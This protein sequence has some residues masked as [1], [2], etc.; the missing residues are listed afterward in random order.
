MSNILVWSEQLSKHLFVHLTSCFHPISET[1]RSIHRPHTCPTQKPPKSRK[2]SNAWSHG[3]PGQA[4]GL[5]SFLAKLIRRQVDVL[6]SLVDCQCS[7]KSLWAKM[8]ADHGK[9]E[10]LR[11]NLRQATG[12]STTKE[13]LIKSI[14]N[15]KSQNNKNLK[16]RAQG[17]QGELQ[18]Q[19]NTC[20]LYE[21]MLYVIY[22]SGWKKLS[23]HLFVQLTSCF[24]PISETPRSIHR[25][26]TCP[27]QKPPKSRKYSEVWS[28]G[29]P[30]QAPG[31]RSFNANVIVSQVDA[32]HCLVD[33]QCSSKSLWT[34]MMADHGK[35]EKLQCN[36][37]QATG[38][39]TTK[40]CLIKSIWKRKFENNKNLK[41]RPQGSQGEPLLQ[42]I[43]VWMNIIV[44]LTYLSG[45]ENCQSTCSSTSHFA[46]IPF[47]KLLDASTGPA[48]VQ[49]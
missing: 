33:F 11:C 25:P 47:Q 1:P 4:P 35:P 41:Q 17:I 8:M 34:N 6:R 29:N 18:L 14:L 12:M 24:H 27:T 43:L 7:S 42:K 26:H 15:C 10:K 21:W 20:I 16:Q 39:S 44:C 37:R 13:C 22:L 3:N 23:K 40:E 9:P 49:H 38:M 30:G 28:H 45:L 48:P 46:F 5:R 32:S 19:K 36:L 2:Y 31:L